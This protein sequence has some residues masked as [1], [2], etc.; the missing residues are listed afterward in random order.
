MPKSDIKW[1]FI[2]HVMLLFYSAGSISSKLASKETFMSFRFL[3]LY[4]ILL[5]VLAGYAIGWQQVIKHLPLTTAYAN[6]AITIIWGILWGSLVFHERV[7]VGKLI[8]ALFVLGGIVL[9]AGAERN[10]KR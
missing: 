10:A 2:M 1:I 3:L 5:L 4:G 8:G 7:T 6:K 9:Y